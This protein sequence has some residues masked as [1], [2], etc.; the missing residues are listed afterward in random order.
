MSLREI[1]EELLADADDSAGEV[2]HAAVELCRS[3]MRV[4]DADLGDALS[5]GSWRL[6]RVRIG[7]FRG[8][9]NGSSTPPL[10]WALP[11]ASDVVIV[12]APNGAGKSTV[13]DA[14][15]VT[16]HG[17][18]RFCPSFV[19]ED[20]RK[21]VPVHRDAQRARVDVGLENDTGHRLDLR[22]DSHAGG[23]SCTASWSIPGTTEPERLSVG[24][25]WRETVSA[26]RPVI[27]YA[28]LDHELRDAGRLSGFFTQSLGLGEFWAQLHTITAAESA[29]ADEA[30]AEWERLRARAAVELDNVDLLLADQYPG[31]EPPESLSPPTDVATV[32]EWFARFFPDM[33]SDGRL[34]EG[35]AAAP[36]NQVEPE[37]ITRLSQV[38]DDATLALR[39]YRRLCTSVADS[40]FAG[41]A[42]DAVRHLLDMTSSGGHDA[43]CPV[44]SSPS[45]GWREVAEESVRR[46]RAID[47]EFKVVRHH[48]AELRAILADEVLPHARAM[49]ESEF[50]RALAPLRSSRPLG[51]DQDALWHALAAVLDAP[52]LVDRLREFLRWLVAEKDDVS[53][54]W[55]DE[56]FRV[57]APLL[58]FYRRAGYSTLRRDSWRR[59]LAQLE[60]T[61]Q[62]VRD[63]RVRALEH[64]VEPPMR[65]FFA[66]AGFDRFG[67]ELSGGL[68]SAERAA[69]RLALSGREVT[70]GSLS[71]G[72][73][74]ALVLAM[75][76]GTGAAGP[77]GF[78]VLDDPVHAFD[79]MRIAALCEQV[80]EQSGQG[81]Q[82]VVFTHDDR[83]VTRLREEHSAATTMR[84]ERDERDE[85]S[86]TDVTH[87]W[88]A[89]VGH[90]DEL[91]T[92]NTRTARD[93]QSTAGP[94]SEQAVVLLA[95]GFCRQAV[96]AALLEV[97]YGWTR[98]DPAAREDF[99]AIHTTSRSIEWALGR[100]P[101]NGPQYAALQ[102]FKRTGC[103]KNLNAAGHGNL[104]ELTGVSLD[105]A[106]SRCRQVM[107]FCADFTGEPAPPRD[108]AE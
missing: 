82:V 96:D 5:S 92:A 17:G 76:F 42:L 48:F 73:F 89:L 97:A 78:L 49:G 106:K 101:V 45:R 91:L 55:H 72:Q 107:D 41:G 2:L 64:A 19:T 102:A 63:E 103:L 25:L 40:S 75:L 71:V 70:T 74:N 4:E 88:Q 46:S 26:H 68:A 34:P 56:R 50:V 104:P 24:G 61:Y 6:R 90:A 58:R 8:A 93:G 1:R 12:H 43:A 52:G 60:S 87:P 79:D 95:L 85:L 13:A 21:Q 59:A 69:L 105:Q 81:R 37:L 36:R 33:P 57:C 44:C 62:R 29:R 94:L 38:A 51:G 7:G 23:E 11:A 47:E 67:I 18:T 84:L 83:V 10:E 80:R 9:A 30:A 15:R 108:E 66:D 99:H 54:Y 3:R 14:L 100:A 28:E 31:T 39:D 27:S 53:A 86:I 20:L 16:L 35:S 32:P 65:A 22:W 77:F 98:G